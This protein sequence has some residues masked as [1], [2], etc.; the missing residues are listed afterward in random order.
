MVLVYFVSWKYK[1]NEETKKPRQIND[2]AFI[3]ST[4]GTQ[5]TLST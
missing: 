3:I 1:Q 4:Q 5:G 2:G